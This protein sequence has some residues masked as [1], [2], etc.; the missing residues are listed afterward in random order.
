MEHPQLAPGDDAHML[1]QDQSTE[2]EVQELDQRDQ[3]LARA[4]TCAY[5]GYGNPPLRQHLHTLRGK[6]SICSVSA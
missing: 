2:E 1:M 4:G 5:I 6:L 3:A